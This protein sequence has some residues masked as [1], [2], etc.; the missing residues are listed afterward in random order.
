V[1]SI[2]PRGE[3]F[4]G[5]N[6]LC[7]LRVMVRWRRSIG[8]PCPTLNNEKEL[9]YTGQFTIFGSLKRVIV[10]TGGIIGDGEHTEPGRT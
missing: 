5:E 2:V 4:D 9:H 3:W 10:G 7:S 6:T 1:E 8:T